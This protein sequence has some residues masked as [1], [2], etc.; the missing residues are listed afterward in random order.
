M[1]PSRLSID[2]TEEGHPVFPQISF[3]QF[4]RLPVGTR[5]L[6]AGLNR[7]IQ[8]DTYNRTMNAWKGD[9]WATPETYALQMRRTG[10]ARFLIC[11][12][13]RNALEGIFGAPITQAEVDFAAEFYRTRASVPHFNEAMWRTVVNDHDGRLP[14]DV[15]CVQDGTAILKG[16]PVLRVSGPG[17]LAAHIEPALHRIFYQ[18]LVATD[19]WRISQLVGNRFIEVGKRGT[20]TEDMHVDATEAMYIGGGIN[21]TSNDAAM[22]AHEELHDVGTMGH[23][24]VQ[25]K[26]TE[27]EA[28]ETAIEKSESSV[29]LLIDLIDSYKGID[30]ALELKKKHR[31]TGKKIW[32]RVDSGD[33]IAQTL[34]ILGRQR[35]LGFTDPA[36]DKVVIED[37][38]E[39]EDMEKIENAVSEA[40]YNPQAF[41]LFGAGGLLVT[42][43]KERSKASTGYKL[44]AVGD[45]PK[46]KFAEPGK[47]SI[48][49]KPELIRCASG[50]RMIAQ[51]GEFPDAKSLYVPAC[52]Q[53]VLLLNGYKAAARQRAI[54]TTAELCDNA[55]TVSAISPVTLLMI[56]N[57]RKH[58]EL[59]E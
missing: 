28:F 39:I 8:T 59:S 50:D 16:D 47:E 56:A 58:Y 38:N 15:D 27:I 13:I 45:T 36:M 57:L 55:Q 42:K 33:L 18:S 35:E 30:K 41:L 51:V 32:I 52:R 40:G 14:L 44:T 7:V 23:R 10:K 5:K 34:Y 49:G 54:T 19:A 48:P 17:E 20:P 21:L 37:L 12:G 4:Q 1:T 3:S 26:N 22:A 29:T 9:E 53:G 11:A 43:D 31:N 24:Y 25:F 6:L 2:F 46:M